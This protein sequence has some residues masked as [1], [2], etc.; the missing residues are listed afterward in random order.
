MSFSDSPHGLQEPLLPRD[1]DLESAI[2][3][4]LKLSVILANSST[5]L[6]TSGWLSIF[7]LQTAVGLV[8]SAPITLFTL[9]IPVIIM[10]LTIASGACAV[11]WLALSNNT[12]AQKSSL[13]LAESLKNRAWIDSFFGLTLIVVGMTL[14]YGCLGIVSGIICASLTSALPYILIGLGAAAIACSIINW[15]TANKARVQ[16]TVS[17]WQPINIALHQDTGA[18]TNKASI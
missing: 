14:K 11:Y 12:T 17:Q 10:C 7:A 18:D 2:K 6:S 5:I 3:K 15:R 4:N 1:D 8:C 16:N 13:S 9:T